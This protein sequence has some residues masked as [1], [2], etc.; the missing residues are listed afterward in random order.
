MGSKASDAQRQGVQRLGFRPGLPRAHCVSSDKS[1]P[2]LRLSCPS[3][4]GG[5]ERVIPL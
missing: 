1:Q 4:N 3:L 2:S 5:L